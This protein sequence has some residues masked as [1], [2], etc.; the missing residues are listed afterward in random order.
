MSDKETS[1]DVVVEEVEVEDTSS[2]KSNDEDKKKKIKS[3]KGFFATTKMFRQDM[4]T[5]QSYKG[6]HAYPV[7]PQD[8]SR[9]AFKTAIG[10]ARSSTARF[11]SGND[12]DP[13]GPLHLHFW[14]LSEALQ[15]EKKLRAAADNIAGRNIKVERGPYR[16]EDE[17]QASGDSKPA[18]TTVCIF[19]IPEETTEEE[20]YERFVNEEDEIRLTQAIEKE[21][22]FKGYVYVQYKSSEDAQKAFESFQ[23][24]PPKF[25]DQSAKVCRLIVPTDDNAKK[26]KK[27]RG[28]QGGSK[29]EPLAIHERQSL[30]STLE[31]LRRQLRSATQPTRRA[32]LSKKIKTIKEQLNKDGDAKKAGTAKKSKNVSPQNKTPKKAQEPAKKKIELPYPHNAW[33]PV[34]SQSQ[35]QKVNKQRLNQMQQQTF[36][37]NPQHGRGRGRGLL[38]MAPS[39]MPGAYGAYD[40]GG[41]ASYP[42]V[43]RGIGRGVGMPPQGPSRMHGGQR[44]DE[45]MDLIG[46]LG[47]MML[48]SKEEG[49]GYDDEW[50]EYSPY[51][52]EPDYYGGGDRGGYRPGSY[53]NLRQS[54]MAWSSLPPRATRGRGRGVAG[55]KQ[56]PGPGAYTRY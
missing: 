6:I 46:Q 40:N 7:T 45:V 51:E 3:S 1:P 32:K 18:D 27:A 44:M 12:K 21:G 25:G 8:L 30:H 31:N 33:E 39:S 35:Q 10:L 14:K 24:N 34:V 43:G 19:D 13:Q 9:S 20:L 4:Q 15:Q 37:Q 48:H 52:Y 2:T 11:F 23:E 49:Y 26:N 47:S 16:P 38:G 55:R 53:T 56:S 42:A 22:N 50:Y 41:P 54:Q 28:A 17:K 5:L 29:E 36:T